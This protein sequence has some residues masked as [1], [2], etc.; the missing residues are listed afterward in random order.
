MAYDD[1]LYRAIFTLFLG[2]LTFVSILVNKVYSLFSLLD[3]YFVLFFFS[4]IL[5]SFIG[6]GMM[7]VWHFK[8][9]RPFYE[10][11]VKKE[12]LHFAPYLAAG[13][14]SAIIGFFLQVY[15]RHMG[16]ALFIISMSLSMLGILLLLN[17]LRYFIKEV[18]VKKPIQKTAAHS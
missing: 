2:F 7:I 16:Q 5:I 4:G 14:V 10:S 12:V 1:I 3:N 8:N 18:L 9:R 15:Y 13:S 6:I 11:E 17:G